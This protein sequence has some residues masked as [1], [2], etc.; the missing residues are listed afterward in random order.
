M[1][2]KSFYFYLISLVNVFQLR[3]MNIQPI[4][5]FL[6]LVQIPSTFLNSLTLLIKCTSESE[7]IWWV[8][9]WTSSRTNFRP[10]FAKQIN[11]KI[12][13]AWAVWDWLLAEGGGYILLGNGLV[14]RIPRAP[15]HSISCISFPQE[16]LHSIFCIANT[17]ASSLSG[18]WLMWGGEKS[19]EGRRATIEVDVVDKVEEVESWGRECTHV[20]MLM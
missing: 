12:F 18:L 5:L 16:T 11:F 3:L 10:V 13:W 8:K 20:H 2:I 6:E 14:S 7:N 4:I 19:K 17:A 15:F 9:F 1:W